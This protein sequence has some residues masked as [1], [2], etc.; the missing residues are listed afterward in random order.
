M[1]VSK[2]RSGH[3]FFVQVREAVPMTWGVVLAF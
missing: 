3:V 2:K 1:D